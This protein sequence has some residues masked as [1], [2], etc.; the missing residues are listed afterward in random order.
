M[1]F[2]QINSRQSFPAIQKF[3]E[4]NE[5][6]KQIENMEVRSFF[7]E[8][9]VFYIRAGK[10]IGFEQNGKGEKFARPFIVI[11]KFNKE[12]FW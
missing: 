3:D 11:K 4:W 8:R 7:K 5:E 12:T 6:K 1:S 2:P 10:N 9:D